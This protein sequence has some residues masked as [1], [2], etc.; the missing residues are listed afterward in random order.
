MGEISIES[1]RVQTDIALT[2]LRANDFLEKDLV[3]I[4][5]NYNDASLEL[6]KALNNIDKLDSLYEKSKNKEEDISSQTLPLI[7]SVSQSVNRA[8]EL[9]QISKK[10]LRPFRTRIFLMTSQ[11]KISD[12]FDDIQRKLDKATE[13][14]STSLTSLHDRLTAIL[15]TY[16]TED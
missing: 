1:A 13:D 8:R 6:E 5:S 12:S 7:D 11:V 15:K 10:I 16:G 9:L 14:V 4:L 3:N 2:G